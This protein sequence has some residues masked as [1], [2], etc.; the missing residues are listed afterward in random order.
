M[1]PAFHIF[2]DE[3]LDCSVSVI[4][5]DMLT[6][7]NAGPAILISHLHQDSTQDRLGGVM[8]RF[9]WKFSDSFNDVPGNIYSRG[10][11]FF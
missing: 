2:D 11:D 9:G 8:S 6:L 5:E 3:V 7:H 4:L 1:L 10:T